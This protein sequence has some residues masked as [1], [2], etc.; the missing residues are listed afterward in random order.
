MIPTEIGDYDFDG[1]LDLMVKFNRT[2]VIAFIRDELGII[3]GDL[4]IIIDGKLNNGPQ[5]TGN[6]MIKVISKGKP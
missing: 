4:T 3:D 5:F 1:I 2:E 6:V